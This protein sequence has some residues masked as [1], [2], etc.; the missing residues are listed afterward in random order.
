MPRTAEG[1]GGFLRFVCSDQEFTVVAEN[2]LY[3]FIP[4]NIQRPALARQAEPHSPA[5]VFAQRTVFANKDLFDIFP[6]V[7]P[8]IQ[9]HREKAHV[10]TVLPDLRI[11]ADDPEKK[12]DQQRHDGRGQEIFIVRLRMG[13]MI[14]KLKKKK[15]IQHQQK[16]PDPD[17]PEPLFFG[18]QDCIVHICHGFN[19]FSGLFNR[20]F[21]KFKE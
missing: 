7:F 15:A 21:I 8:E 4:R 9:A 12:G 18:K 16:Q 11:Q 3:P 20:V 10:N 17:L 6:G 19:E 14:K 5:S 13:G 1:K 2:N